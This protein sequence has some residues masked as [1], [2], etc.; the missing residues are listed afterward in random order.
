MLG[1]MSPSLSRTGAQSSRQ[2]S[3]TNAAVW[4][5]PER[6]WPSWA[7]GRVSSMLPQG[8]LTLLS[9][10]GKTTLLNV[11][12]HR[13]PAD[14]TVEQTRL[15]NGNPVSLD[16]FRRVSCYVEQEDALLGVLTVRE[17]L[18]FAAKLSLPSSVGKVERMN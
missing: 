5:M 17:T 18:H 15:L 4:S 12:A 13:E 3:S 14:A 16:E 7:Q 8:M 10:C 11:L 2:P 9:G 6:C 1:K